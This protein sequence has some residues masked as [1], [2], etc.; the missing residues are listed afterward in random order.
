MADSILLC[1]TSVGPEEILASLKSER[2]PT[3]W[4]FLG[5]DYLKLLEWRGLLGPSADFVDI[6]PL[7]NRATEQLREP[8]LQLIT[9]LGR[10]YQSIAW[11]ASR[12]SERN[13]LVSALFL[14]CCYLRIGQESLSNHEGTLCVVGESWALL[15]SLSDFGNSN[16]CR[17]KWVKRPALG[18][19]QIKFL[20]RIGKHLKHF[21]SWAIRQRESRSSPRSFAGLPSC[22]LLRTWVDEACFREEGVFY[23]RYLPGLCRWLE[24]QGFSVVT[25]PVLENLERS[26]H[27]AWRWLRNSQQNFLNPFMYYKIGDYLFALRV[28]CQQIFMP[29]GPVFLDGLDVSRLF[30]AE[31]EH[32]AFNRGSLE[33]ILS[34]RL[35][36]RLAEAG[37]RVRA[38]IEE[39]ENMI[40]EKP[41]ILGFRRSFPAAKLVGFQHGTL[42]PLLLSQFITAGESE[43]API[44]DTVVCNGAFFR[45]ILIQ[46][47]L[48]PGRAVVGPA[49]RYGHLWQ[50][51]GKE[52]S[53][54]HEPGLILIPLPLV[55]DNAVELLTKVIRVFENLESLRIRLKPHP[56]SLRESIFRAAQIKEL[57][58]HFEFV[59]GEMDEWLE[60]A[61]L[62]IGLGS[63]TVYEALAAGVP[64]IV[65]ARETALNFNPLAWYLDLNQEFCVPE[66]IRAE[67][68]RL[69]ALSPEELTDYR[70]RA[71]EVLSSSFQPVSEEA[72]RAFVSGIMP[73][74]NE[75]T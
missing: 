55:L 41:L 23:D 68:L 20:V 25:I 59:S 58:S 3:R 40:P 12:V 14:Y 53:R 16:D 63:S 48:P 66:D 1:H 21:I 7:L 33:A 42:N 62:V 35:P 13:T 4:L 27:S 57:P 60:R 70:Q 9:E 15:E 11:W 45:D 2:Y 37:L 30:K 32:L 67:A 47:G 34:Y 56:M 28:A 44:P 17:V 8:F 46:E 64:V 31:R 19:R 71:T 22:I 29:A 74:R 10:R 39:F 6:G 54:S 5:Q 52:N 51:F 73:V 75:N 36:Q 38:L 24:A 26:N 43:F 65:V 61:Q 18:R 50:K 49:L 72:M 69:L